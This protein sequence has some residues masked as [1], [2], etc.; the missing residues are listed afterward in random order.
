MN[1]LKI[2][3]TILLSLFLFIF[4]SHAII[5]CTPSSADYSYN[6]NQ[7]PTPEKVQ[8]NGRV[9]FF[10]LPKDECKTNVFLIKNDKLLKYR[11]VNGFSFVNYINKN[12]KNGAVVDGW[13]RSDEIVSDNVEQNGLTYSDFSWKINGQNVNLLGKATPEL[14]A[15]GKLSG[16][17]LPEPEKHGFYNEFES[18]TLTILNEMITISQANE[19]IE[20][21]L[22]LNDTNVSGITFVDSKYA[23][24]CGV[25]VGDDWS[26]VTAKYGAKSKLNSENGCR[27]YLYFDMKLSFCLDQSKKY[28]P[29]YLKTTL[30]NRSP[31]YGFK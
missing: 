26:T 22:G 15:W 24:A 6:T 11:V 8:S 2:K 14:N 21:R 20:K 7:D 23:T 17:K 30:K 18:W 12:G 31:L 29:L 28:R 25:K 27:F 16:L 13:V 3:I 5:S 1:K 19:I 10:S 9:Y 4:N